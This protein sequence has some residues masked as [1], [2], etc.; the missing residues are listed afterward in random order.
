MTVRL[1]GQARATAGSIFIITTKNGKLIKQI[2]KG[3]WEV[4]QFLRRGSKKRLGLFFRNKGQ[5][6]SDNTFTESEPMEA[7]WSC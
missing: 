4:G 7:D 6:R 3:D 5:I 1:F 2:T